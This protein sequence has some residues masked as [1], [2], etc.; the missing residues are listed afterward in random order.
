MNI[1]HIRYAVEVAK[2]GSIN[3]ASESLGMAQPN[4]S[5]AIK[6]LESDLGIVIFD[7]SAKG[8]NLT[9]EGKEFIARAQNILTQINELEF[10]YRG[11]VVK[12]QRFSVSVPRAGYISEAFAEFSHKI[13]L[14]AAEIVLD[15][16]STFNTI[17]KLISSECKL[18]IIRYDKAADE[19]FKETLDKNELEYETISDFH[20]SVIASRKSILAGLD[21]V[22]EAVLREMIQITHSDPYEATLSANGAQKA[23]LRQSSSRCIYIVDTAAQ[24]ELLSENPN[25]FMWVSPVPKKLLDRFE[26]VQL[27][28][29]ANNKCYKDV[30]V[31][32]KNH[33]L[34]TLDLEFMDAVKQASE[35]LK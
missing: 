8:M 25:T 17:K 11:G 27:K 9:P 30:F 1:I 14:P 29:T 20:Y 28:S 2:L 12:T 32:R 5:R 26:L 4:I 6:E 22:N 34:S 33:K 19:Y 16:T 18:G 10:F 7:R 21:T 3:K 31:Y 35:A 23:E 15:E 24:L 13:G